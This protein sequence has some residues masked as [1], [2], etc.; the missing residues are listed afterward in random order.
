[1]RQADARILVFAK[2]PLAGYSKRRLI[3]AL[4]PRGAAQ[5]HAELVRR[6][7]ATATAAQLAPVE[8]WCAQQV[9]HAFFRHCLDRFPIR[10]KQQQGDDLGQ[11]MAHA[12]QATLTEVKHVLLIGC[13][14]P[15]L[16][17]ADLDAAL[18][19]LRQ[20]NACVLKPAEDGGYVLIGL[21][22]FDAALFADL[23]WGGCHVMAT[24]RAR[25]AA[26]DWRWQALASSWDV[27]RPEDLERL[28]KS[29]L[30]I[31]VDYQ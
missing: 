5:L 20:G 11:R 27:D 29:G 4:G 16:T 18:H 8:L 19:S 2:P 15:A 24:T 22:R 14:C 30:P 13:D 6:T 25:L 7:L 17:A 3:P 23:P 1:M 21:S 26:L 28:K 9:G 10:L 31:A 12:F